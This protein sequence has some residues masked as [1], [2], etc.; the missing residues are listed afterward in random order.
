MLNVHTTYVVRGKKTEAPG[1]A[2]LSLTDRDGL[3]PHF[4]PGQYIT[5]FFSESVI[6]EGKAYSISSAP[7]EMRFDITVRAIGEFSNMLGA[8]EIGDTI[9]GSLPYGFFSPETSEKS[10]VLVAG[11]IG[12]TPFR[13]MIKSSA[14][15]TPDR[16]I[17][18]FHSVRIQD[19]AIFFD[20]F[21]EIARTIPLTHHHFVTREEASS[22]G[23]KTG[24]ITASRMLE[25]LPEGDNFEF[26]L[27]GSI[28][29]TR[30]LWRGLRKQ[31][32]LEEQIYT[33]AFFNS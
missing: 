11:G 10:L 7:H 20:E 23:M 25:E 9:I 2:T 31:G 3:V 22:P 1:I 27:C 30:D 21:K 6:S 32:V 5:V 17:H 18:L 28:S 12:V 19:D 14:Y 4:L 15:M 8:L 26:L 29:F 16:P 13:S 24:R 33:E